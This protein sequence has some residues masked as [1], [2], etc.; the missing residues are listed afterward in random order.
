MEHQV[1]D[2]AHPPTYQASLG[3]SPEY[4]KPVIPK[5]FG[6][7]DWFLEGNFSTDCCGRGWFQDYSSY[8]IYCALYF[9]YYYYISTTPAQTLALGGW[10]PCKLLQ[11]ICRR[12]KKGDYI[13]QAF[14]AIN[15]N[16]HISLH[17]YIH[18]S[19]YASS[20]FYSTKESGSLHW[21]LAHK[22]FTRND[23][24]AS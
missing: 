14:P 7:R 17:K 3:K 24:S 21:G 11:I 4:S 22:S 6:T 1:T 18:I 16:I 13:S 20:L 19:L 12:K 23:S 2:P 5:I 15:T 10:G 9:Y 8:D